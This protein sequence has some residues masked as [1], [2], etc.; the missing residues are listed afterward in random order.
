MRRIIPIFIG[1]PIA[2]IFLIIF[3]GGI[4]NAGQIFL[5]SVVCTAGISLLIWVPLWWFIGWML[6]KIYESV[7]GRS[8]LRETSSGS[9]VVPSNYQTSLT[10]DQIAL[11]NYIEQSTRQGFSE[12]QIVSRLRAQGWGDEEIQQAQLLAR[13]R[14]GS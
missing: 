10:H 8:I 6:I 12:T 9:I 11:K 3:A 14:G 13:G 4:Q 7:T 5:L 2:F 1:L